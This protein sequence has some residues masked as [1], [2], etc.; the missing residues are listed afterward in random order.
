MALAAAGG[1]SWHLDCLSAS[2]FP[3]S[4]TS[5]SGSGKYEEIKKTVIAMR[6]FFSDLVDIITIARF[7]IL[8]CLHVSILPGLSPQMTATGSSWLVA[9]LT[10]VTGSAVTMTAI[11]KVWAGTCRCT[12][13]AHTPTSTTLAASVSPWPWWRSS[14]CHGVEFAAI[15]V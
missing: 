8:S 14:S 5:C 6:V 2:W 12:D 11:T 3:A 13:V 4:C 15:C 7:T 9:G 10:A 1:A